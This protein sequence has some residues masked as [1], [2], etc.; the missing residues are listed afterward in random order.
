VAVAV[1]A[2]VVVQAS[3]VEATAAEVLPVAESELDL[4]DIFPLVA[5]RMYLWL[6]GT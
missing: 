5:V 2:V 6:Q 4:V 3:T 1:P